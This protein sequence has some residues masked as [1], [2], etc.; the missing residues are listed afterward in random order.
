MDRIQAEREAFQEYLEA[1]VEL[2]KALRK[3]HSY[4]PEYRDA[5]F[6]WILAEY[7]TNE[8]FKKRCQN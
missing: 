1:G 6:Q 2:D 4:G 8:A 5:D 7:E 3:L